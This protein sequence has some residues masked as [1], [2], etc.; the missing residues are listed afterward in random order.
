VAWRDM[1]LCRGIL[2]SGDLLVD[3]MNVRR[4]L[5]PENRG[6]A[7]I[8]SIVISDSE[9]RPPIFTSVE[10]TG[11]DAVFYLLCIDTNTLLLKITLHICAAIQASLVT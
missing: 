8:K 10:L 3:G 4:A 7:S 11:I 5:T 9:K 1:S 2:T 6:I